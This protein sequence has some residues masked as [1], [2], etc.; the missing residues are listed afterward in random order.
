MTAREIFAVI[1]KDGVIS[2]FQF[3]N[4][5]VCAGQAGCPD[6]ILPYRAG[7]AIK[8]ILKDAGAKSIGS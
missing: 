4:K 1:G 8:D 5:S 7:I 3:G 2:R 6:G